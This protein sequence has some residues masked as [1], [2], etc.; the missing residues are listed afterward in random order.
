MGVDWEEVSDIFAAAIKLPAAKRGSFLEKRCGSNAEL[1]KEVERLL[2]EDEAAVRERFLETQAWRLEVG[3]HELPDLEGRE[4]GAYTIETPIARGGMGDVYRARRTDG[5]EQSVA[6]KL[7]RDRSA[8]EEL[9]ARFRKEVNFQARVSQHPNIAGLIDAGSTDDGTFYL[10]MEYVDGVTIKE[11]CQSGHLGLRQRIELFQQVCSAVSFAHQHLVI[12]RDLKP[13]NILVTETGSP[14]LLDFGIAGEESPDLT[15]GTEHR[16]LTPEYASPEQLRGDPLS[17]ATDV[18]SLGVVL[19][20][21]LIGV[22]PHDLTGLNR[23]ERERVICEVDAPRPSDRLKS[24][25]TDAAE[26]EPERTSTTSKLR[27][28]IAGDLD[29]ILLKALERDPNDRYESVVELSND[30][31]RF[32]DGRPVMATRQTS[33]YLM[34]RF[35]RRN[36]VAVVSVGLVAAA[37]IAGVIGTTIGMFEASQQRQLAEQQR[38]KADDL[39]EQLLLALNGIVDEI[40]AVQEDASDV[41]AAREMARQLAQQASRQL[42]NFQQAFA[43]DARPEIELAYVYLAL[44]EFA[45]IVNRDDDEDGMTQREYYQEAYR[46]AKQLPAEGESRA[47]VLRIR[48]RCALSLGNRKQDDDDLKGA[49][50]LYVEARQILETMVNEQLANWDDHSSLASASSHLGDTQVAR[51]E[52]ALAAEDYQ[53]AHRRYLEV[54]AERPGDERA[55]RALV[56]SL[57]LQGRCAH[58]AGDNLTAGRFYREANERVRRIVEEHGNAVSSNTLRK[59][60]ATQNKLGDLAFADDLEAAQAAYAEGLALAQRLVERDQQNSLFQDDLAVSHMKM[61][62]VRTAEGKL[63]DALEQYEAAHA[64]RT[65]LLDGDD[66]DAA[67][68]RNFYRSCYETAR[69]SRRLG[70][71]ETAAAT[72]LAGIER[73]GPMA[74]EESASS[75]LIATCAQLE[76]EGAD[77]LRRTGKFREAAD[78]S[79]SAVDR[80]ARADEKFQRDTFHETIQQQSAWSHY[81]RARADGQS[82]LAAIWEVEPDQRERLLIKVGLEQAYAGGVETAIGLADALV[83]LAAGADKP[84]TLY[85]AACIYALCAASDD[86]QVAIDRAFRVL[87]EELSPETLANPT[88]HEALRTDDDLDAIRPLPRFDALLKRVEQEANRRQ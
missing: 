32:L 36:R 40:R 44:A 76:V 64:I 24:S 12:H 86:P 72:C 77:S 83:E 88:F 50:Q 66:R 45:E 68:R 16:A 51:K 3:G 21:L 42:T 79:D 5:I 57:Y 87:T 60:M 80:L 25:Q 70:D 27:R 41:P 63:E 73:L 53:A 26:G 67:H 37:L 9:V 75:P 85:T 33:I 54:A 34:K 14:Y 55:A 23:H 65:R 52:Y 49:D 38:N 35:I 47:E 8:A 39:R 48:A 7:I 1:R 19:F 29:A 17:T 81:N 20:E 2:A 71:L 18:Y 4:F 13:S 62:K 6:V 30:L 15:T 78:L 69:T 56:T 61:G 11:Y 59:M 43:D 28:A 22:R 46:I 31:Q 10:V 84:V 74:K 82:A 58:K